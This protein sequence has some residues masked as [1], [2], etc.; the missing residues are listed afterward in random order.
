M[1]INPMQRK[2]RNS[3]LIGFLIP[4]L[5]L[6]AVIGILIY[7]KD[8]EQKEQEANSE[9]VYMLV[10]NI[11]SGVPITA[12]DI[13]QVKV[14]TDVNMD[15]GKVATL[16]YITENN[17]ARI[18]LCKGVIL[19]TDMLTKADENTEDLKIQEY[20][21]VL[22]PTDLAKNDYVDL[23]I[24]FANGQDYIIVSKKRV[25]SSSANTIFLKM[26]EAEILTMSNAIVE[27][28]MAIG[29]LIYA[30][31]Y[32]NAGTQQAATPTYNVSREVLG[33]INENPNITNEARGHLWERYK[34]D[35]RAEIDNILSTVEDKATSVS[36]GIE[37]QV[38]KQ[39]AE[40]A[41][42]IESLGVGAD[43]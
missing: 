17:I 29:S 20:N 35:R 4:T 23:R 12:A 15:K 26:T 42:Y 33:L 22:L 32:E 19:S 40:R 3:F 18:N 30:D 39:E 43:Y 31:K 36:E 38:E 9:K 6:G 13:K 1:A 37:Q 25:L 10:N 34:T 28:Y 27:S 11:E 2:A 16:D 21:M 8:Q 41:R 7:Q 14:S 5:I 24:R